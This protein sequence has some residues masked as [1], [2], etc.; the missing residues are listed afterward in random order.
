MADARETILIVDDKPATIEMP[1]HYLG[2]KR[3][4]VLD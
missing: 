1:S 3:L 4:G 2:G